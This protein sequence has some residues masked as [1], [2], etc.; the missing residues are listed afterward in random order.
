MLPNQGFLASTSTESYA[1]LRQNFAPW[2]KTAEMF[3][4]LGMQILRTMKA[5]QTSNQQLIVAILYGR[6]LTSFQAAY[7]LTE[8]GMLA[9]ART[10]IR[11]AAE[12]AIILCAVVKD[13]NVID[14]LIERHY[15]HNRKLRNAWLNDQEA[16]AG[17]TPQEIE[18]IKNIIAEI[19]KNY[20]KVKH[21]TKDPISIENLA[22]DANVT[23]IYNAVYRFSSGDAAHTTIEALD[24][25]LVT[26]G[27]S[28]IKGI[29]FGPEYRDLPGT[30]HCAMSVLGFSM[31]SILK[32]FK[33]QQFSDDLQKCVSSWNALGAP[34][35]Y[36][37][38]IAQSK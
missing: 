16:V 14:R 31:D 1:Q 3:N 4:D 36:K 8:R 7:I 6:A 12:T 9:D 15:W 37:L 27:E 32:L 22:R 25:H 10:V 30:L 5:D 24:R 34:R 13:E 17:M 38:E 11:A 2:F 23:S 18:A 20:P 35:E 33:L 29:K 28:N 26:D 21:L 19:D